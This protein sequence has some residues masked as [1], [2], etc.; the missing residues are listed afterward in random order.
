MSSNSNS[1][2]KRSF[3]S[4]SS[5]P[6][7]SSNNSSADDKSKKKKTAQK[8]LGMAWGPNSRSGF[9]NSP[10]SDFGSYMVVKNQKLHEQ[11]DA[12]A[13]SSSHGGTRTGNSIFCGVS[14]FVDGY[15]VPSSQELRGYMLKYGG[16]FE[17][18]FS[19]HRVTHIICSNLPDSKI[20]NLRAFSGGLPVV[21]PTWV[22]DSV[23]A[24]KL[25]SWVPYQLD[26]LAAENDN[27]PKLSAFFTLKSSRVSEITDRLVNGQSICEN[28][29][30]SLDK[31][32][33]S[34]SEAN[35][36]LQLKD[37]CSVEP[38]DLL[39]TDNDNDITEEPAC[40]VESTCEIERVEMIDTSPL[41]GRNSGCKP[42]SSTFEPSVSLC[43]N[44]L[45]THNN[46][47]SSSKTEFPPNQRHST[48]ADPNF[49]ENYFKSSRLHFIGTWR[50]RYRNRFPSSS[51]RF[52]YKSHSLDTAAANQKSAIIHIDMD[53]FFVS[54]VIRNHPDL[55]DKPV[56]VC[57]SDNARG[58]AEISSANYPARDHGVKAGMFVKDARTRCP[59]LVIV[60]YD[61]GAYEKV[62]DQFYEILHKHCDKVQAVSCD[63]AFLDVS[64]SE[65]DDPQLLASTIRQEIID[66][67]GCT[68]SVDGYLCSLPVKALPGI[69]YVLE[70]KL[71]KRQIE[72]CGQLRMFT[73]ESLQKDFGMKT[74]EMLWNYSRGIDNRLVGLIQESKSI[75]AE[76]NWG[77]RFRDL[78]DT[79]H[80]LKNL[81]KEVA[82]RLQGC[83]VQGRSF[84]L[85]IK[86]RRREAGEPVKYMGCGECVNLSHTTT[87]PMATNDVDVLQRLATQLFGYFNLDVKDVRGVGLQVSKLEGADDGKQV[88]AR[89]QKN[90]PVVPNHDN[91]DVKDVRGVGLQVSKL[92]GADDGKQVKARDQKNVPVVPNHDNADT[93]R[94]SNGEAQVLPCS[95]T[96]EPFAPGGAGLS[97]SI[98]DVSQTATL[99][100]LHDLDVAIIESLPPEVVSEINDMYGGKL[101]GFISEYK[102]KVINANI[103]HAAPLTSGE[104][105]AAD[106]T[107]SLRAHLVA[108][109]TITGANEELQCDESSVHVMSGSVSQNNLM[110]TSLSQV[111]CS[112]LQ[113]L[114]EELRK[115]II[116]L[117]PPHRTPEI[118]KGSSSNR[119]ISEIHLPLGMGIEGLD[120]AVN[121][122]SELFKQYVELKVATDIEE[123]YLC[124]CLLRRLTGRSEVFSQVYNII[125]PHLQVLGGQI[126]QFLVFL[127]VQKNVKF[128]LVTK[129]ASAADSASVDGASECA[130]RLSK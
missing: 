91:A 56:A 45:G 73:K 108:S 109:N 104:G 107:E 82:L 1:K 130:A 14:I 57:H 55:L 26:Q 41:D 119:M 34:L 53:C 112:V 68:A 17:N 38:E 63:E 76:V 46:E 39:P 114:P 29:I 70:E 15:T 19:R 25:L 33:S 16:R 125:L 97:S 64:E 102:G 116:E 83:R 128:N 121:C 80:F 105:V 67:T 9:S 79:Q 10:F 89:D 118:V 37:R 24:D 101:L 78:N 99:P 115:D 18:Y 124:I 11:F 3:K 106:E 100:P 12:A 52:K 113:Q 75:G 44:K 129:I 36:I 60:P 30:T 4:I 48:L 72:T 32:D 40:S 61:F 47:A 98:S 93:W 77:V 22:L 54:V 27:Q 59:Q 69:G 110:P 96:A 8:T 90:V 123:I 111:D 42:T 87:I 86:K 95:D 81:C 74:G 65:V 127:S 117:L 88:K 62:A 103:M 51:N 35:S 6:S 20:K 50:N 85:K 21:K 7:S 31:V 43:N 84:T 126:F 5:N 49:V 58:A 23:A 28:D 66:T 92:E 94:L 13:S 120:N 71:K 2:S 122:L